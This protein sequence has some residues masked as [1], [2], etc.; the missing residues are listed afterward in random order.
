V[1][2]AV[3]GL[4]GVLSVSVN[5]ATEVCDVTYAS[6]Q[7]TIRALVTALSDVRARKYLKNDI[8][9]FIIYELM[10]LYM[11][12]AGG[13]YGVDLSGGRGRAGKDPTGRNGIPPI[14]AHLQRHLRRPRF[15]SRQSRSTH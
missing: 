4:P 12:G 10:N 5:L 8:N 2:G 9:I 1:E 11:W 15:L 6:G 7:V 3:S 14:H 13:L